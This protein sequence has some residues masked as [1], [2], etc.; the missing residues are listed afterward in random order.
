VDGSLAA[1]RAVSGMQRL[2]SLRMTAVRLAALG[3]GF[4]VPTILAVGQR[5]RPYAGGQR[6]AIDD[7]AR[8]LQALTPRTACWRR[9]PRPRSNRRRRA[10]TRAA[11]S[12]A[13]PMPP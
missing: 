7:C 12:R 6:Q 8:A 3:V 1:Q 11:G 9:T 4:V 13:I 2:S 5:D 10:A